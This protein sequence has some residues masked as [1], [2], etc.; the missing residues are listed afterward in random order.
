[1]VLLKLSLNVDEVGI[2]I[3][4]MH[5]HVGIVIA[6]FMGNGE[7]EFMSIGLLVLIM[8]CFHVSCANTYQISLKMEPQ[9]TYSIEW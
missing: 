2:N 3:R 8:Y 7:Y 1:M 4:V 6:G 5:C 9:M